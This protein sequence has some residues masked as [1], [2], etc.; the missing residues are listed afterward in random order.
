MRQVLAL[1]PKLQALEA[2]WAQLHVVSGADTADGLI[3]FWQRASPPAAD[4]PSGTSAT[5]DL[6]SAVCPYPV[7]S[8]SSV[9]RSAHRR[10]ADLLA[11]I[12]QCDEPNGRSCADLGSCDY[13][14][15]I[16]ATHAPSSSRGCEAQY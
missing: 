2:Q 13:V 4:P 8:S 7:S 14:V 16:A 11:A 1:Q 10:N 3:A 9:P 15:S 12:C 5:P 6:H